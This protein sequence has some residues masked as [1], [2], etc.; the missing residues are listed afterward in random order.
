MEDI[1]VTTNTLPKCYNNSECCCFDNVFDKPTHFNPADILQY[2]NLNLQEISAYIDELNNHI[3][4][5]DTL[6]TSRFR[7]VNAIEVHKAN[8][9]FLETVRRFQM[10]LLLH[11]D[12]G[13]FFCKYF[14]DDMDVNK[15]ILFYEELGN[16]NNKSIQLFS[17]PS[18]PLTA[19]N[20]IDILDL[21]RNCLYIFQQ[22]YNVKNFGRAIFRK[23]TYNVN[24]H[25]FQFRNKTK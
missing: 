10:Q 22:F 23:D 5:D 17:K 16:I 2:T 11:R 13:D 24:I 15:L 19:R 12:K 25:S 1:T 9:H 14:N 18:S 21:H 4:L 8:Q 20:L 7:N 3:R 6:N